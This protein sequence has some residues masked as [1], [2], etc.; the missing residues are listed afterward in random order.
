MSGHLINP[1]LRMEVEPPTEDELRDIFNDFSIDDILEKEDLGMTLRYL[2]Q[3]PSEAE[4]ED[5]VNEFGN[6]AWVD[7]AG[8]A[9]LI[10]QKWKKIDTELELREAFRVFDRDGNGSLDAA[11]LRRL[12][13]SFDTRI[14]SAAFGDPDHSHRRSGKTRHSPVGRSSR[15]WSSQVRPNSWR[16][17]RTAPAW[18]SSAS[19]A[20][21]PGA[22]PGGLAG[23]AV[24]C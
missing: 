21:M 16:A 17:E 19:A 4:L 18:S 3:N 22:I 24:R 5:W 2:F 6:G 13:R 20:R 1:H 10:S 15:S 14:S 8:F 23:C 7:F 9:D 11:E 12:R